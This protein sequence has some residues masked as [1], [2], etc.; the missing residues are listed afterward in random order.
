LAFQDEVHGFWN[1]GHLPNSI[2]IEELLQKHPSIP[3]NPDIA[4]TLFRCGDIDVWGRGYRKIVKSVLEHKQLPPEII[5]HKQTNSNPITE[6]IRKMAKKTG[7][8]RTRNKLCDKVAWINWL[9][10]GS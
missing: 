3:Y 2:S 10:I 8:T 9:I 7:K 4:N 5:K 6:A 1:P